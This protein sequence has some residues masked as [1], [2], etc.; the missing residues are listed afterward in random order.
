MKENAG[1]AKDNGRGLI[2]ADVLRATS[3]RVTLKVVE[4][5]GDTSATWKLAMYC[6]REMLEFLRDDAKLVDGP[7]LLNCDVDHIA[8]TDDDGIVVFVV[9]RSERGDDA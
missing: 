5:V 4:R 9:F 1:N 7:L 6:G 3:G 8:G 2:L